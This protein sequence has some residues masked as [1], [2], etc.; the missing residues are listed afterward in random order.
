[1]RARRSSATLLC[2]R[3]AL[4][5][6]RAYDPGRLAAG[7]FQVSTLSSFSSEFDPSSELPVSSENDEREGPSSRDSRRIQALVRLLG[8]TDEKILKVA[9]EELERS[10]VQALAF[11]RQAQRESPDE[12][13]RV[14]SRRF[15]LEWRRREV[16][17][18]W[19][20]FC[21][22]E[23][24]DLE[25]GAFIIARTENPDCDVETY[26]ATLDDYAST[27][28]YR[29]R[30]SAEID[31]TIGNIGDFLFREIGFRG[32]S[33]NY[34]GVENSYLNRVIDRKAG[35]PIT[36]SAIFLLVCRRLSLSVHGVGMPR[37]FLLK[38]R[39][40]TREYF[41][42]A[43]HG[44][45]VLSVHDCARFLSSI[46]V[47][48]RDDYLQA[49]SDQAILSR[50]LNNLFRSYWGAKDER[51]ANRVAAMQKLLG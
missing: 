20:Q 9:W 4:L 48:F 17:R 10:G 7:G 24:R 38:Y 28:R 26:R 5:A 16:F 14:Q 25:R 29:L 34:N 22:G 13:V 23:R 8:D 18:D 45:R 27:L 12:R 44:G 51:R 15:L 39:N 6:E 19:V 3:R 30:P 31:E 49:V 37:H 47:P 21:K 42:D 33:T 40:E 50:M 43:F 35:I 36:L 11:L 32:D 46:G 41:I 1:M 2:A